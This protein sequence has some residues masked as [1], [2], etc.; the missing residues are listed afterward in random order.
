M[1]IVV[2]SSR[3]Y[4]PE[5]KRLRA[6]LNDGMTVLFP[7]FE[8]DNPKDPETLARLHREFYEKIDSAEAL[9][10]Y[11][12]NGYTGASVLV[13]I[14]YAR[15]KGKKIYTLEPAEELAVRDASLGHV[16]LTELLK[17]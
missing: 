6:K 7:N 5:L 11:N 2:A 17:K 10:V 15:A 4:F 13:E 12:K 1:K 9:Y 3:R 14:G 8:E 16:Q